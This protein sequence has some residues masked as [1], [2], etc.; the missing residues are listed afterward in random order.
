[1][2]SI[3]FPASI[4]A[5]RSSR[6]PARWMPATVPA[7][8]A[9]LA[10]ELSLVPTLLPRTPW[11]QGIF[12]GVVMVH[13]YAAF[14]AL[15]WAVAHLRSRVL[16]PPRQ[17]RHA[18][19][20]GTGT[21]MGAAARIALAIGFVAAMVAGQLAGLQLAARS[22]GPPPPLYGTLE[23]AAVGA[24][25]AAALVLIGRGI[26]STARR[27][28]GWLRRSRVRTRVIAMVAVV[29]IVPVV[30]ADTPQLPSR[31]PA[32]AADWHASVDARSAVRAGGVGSAVPWASLGAKGQ[33][34]VAGGPSTAEIRAVTG[35]PAVEPIRVYVGL[36]SAPTPSQR[37]ALAV[38][39]LRRTGALRR[40]AIVLTVPTGSGWVNPAAPAALEFLYGGDVAT[41]AVQYSDVPSWQEYLRGLGAARATSQA[42]VGAVG[43]SVR[44]GGGGT[45]APRLILYGESLGAL[46]ALS[47][48]TTGEDGGDAG[49]WVG[50]P[51]DAPAATA[52]DQVRLVHDDDPVAVWSPRLLFGPTA[53][54]HGRW[55][56]FVSFWQ[57][58]ADMAAAYAIPSGHGHRYGQEFVDAWN[59]LVPA[60]GV[61]G[62]APP[63]RFAAIRH[64]VS[65]FFIES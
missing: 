51:A 36:A 60:H 33:E 48:L 56:P 15:A 44:A 38:D 4:R 30:G 23:A 62:A 13:T 63:D 11:I 26:R 64:A 7:M 9:V 52:A 39:E 34:F 2:T 8:L 35:R 37:A 47:S 59:S 46:A 31:A 43:S 24:A 6:A 53:Q 49:L 17:G 57:A 14:V 32:A 20:R 1:M 45:S 61:V 54:W 55:Y 65:T 42:L 12:T 40:A 10:G 28:L 22:D 5:A 58:T 3:A 18:A 19:R 25:V 29:A 50:V 27:I 21:W 41:V 16:G